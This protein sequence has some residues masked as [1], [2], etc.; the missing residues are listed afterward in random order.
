MIPLTLTLTNFL[1]WRE[2]A[3]LDFGSLHLAGITGSNGAGKSSL[4]EAITWSLFGRSRG[5]SDDDVVHR[6]AVQKGESA[7][8]IFIF[9][10]GESHYRV[11]RRKKAGGRMALEFQI[12][13]EEGGWT[14]L[15]ET[16]L[17][18]TQERIEQ[19]LGMNYDT[20]VNVSFFMQGQADAFT[21][22]TP[23]QRKEILAELLGVNRWDKLK[24][25]AVER[26]K[27]AETERDLIDARLRD[28]DEELA[29]SGDRE[30]E[31]AMARAG[32]EKAAALLAAQ[33]ALL[34]TLRRAAEAVSRQQEGLTRLRQQQERHTTRTA[35]LERLH[36]IRRRERESHQGWLDQRSAIEQESADHEAAWRDLE[37]WQAKAEQFN[38]V[39]H[40]RRPHELALAQQESTLRARQTALGA[41]Q[42]QVAQMRTERADL[43]AQIAATAQEQAA[44]GDRLERLAAE[45]VAWRE[46]R[47]LFQTMQGERRLR[48][49][50]AQALRKE[51]ATVAR[52]QQER[53]TL[54]ASAD[55][56]TRALADLADRLA[57]LE[58]DRER[59]ATAQGTL[60]ALEAQQGTLKAE[61]ARLK[62]RI[63]RLET[64]TGE[65]AGA[66][67]LCGQPLSAEHRARALADLTAEGKQRGDLFR[68]NQQ[69]AL[70]LKAETQRLTAALAQS[71]DLER[72]RQRQ[73]QA[74]AQAQARHD[75]IGRVVADWEAAQGADRLAQAEQFLADQAE[76]TAL[77]ERIAALETAL[78]PRADWQAALQTLGRQHARAEARL[79]EIDRTVARWDGEER[80]QLEEVTQALESADFGIAERQALAQ[81]EVQAVAIGYD[82][83]RHA[84]ARTR[85]DG[86]AEAPR[87]LQALREAEAAIKPLDDALADLAAQLADQAAHATELADQLALEEARLVT[88]RA[89]AGDLQ[90]AERSVAD[91]REQQIAANRR[92]GVAQQKVA[93][94]GDQRTRQATLTAEKGRVNRR[95]QQL[96]LL[97]K[98]CGRDGVQALLI[99]HALPQIED[100]ANRLLEQL[101]EGAMHLSFD[102][103]RQLRSRD[104]LRETL[105]I[106]ISDSNGERPYE[107][108]SGGEQFRIN[109]A[110]RL[111]LSRVLAQR[112]GARL[113]TL[114]IDEGF[115]SQDPGGRQ[116]LIEAINLIQDDFERI[117][118]ITHIDELRDAF[119]VRIEVS[120]SADGSRLR[121][122]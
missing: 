116:R 61:M 88:L 40:A 47:E 18:E 87:R 92:V 17:R 15:S 30:A 101:T 14:T 84:A 60:H 75:E 5:R 49:Q 10:L 21:T 25:R 66:C 1:S 97:E 8:V 111:A 26:R 96:Q 56:A 65:E 58:R 42:T 11:A 105:D 73:E 93:V 50:A 62:E 52:L 121:V 45:E 13:S 23:N 43:L 70:A 110:I 90:S 59:L 81:L 100:H 86:L 104:A 107:N 39:Q 22:R 35:D 106:T 118:V 53:V 55:T 41:Q 91:L 74:V 34:L 89:D 27:S 68:A 115:G 4:I 99:E 94:L 83:Q 64:E 32:F 54:S 77:Q 63:K 48:E 113:Q 38:A 44:L 109:F 29:L 7:A 76:M 102:T 98:A 3:T 19:T 95:I 12:G 82:A 79:A 2:S 9:A 24:E 6:V 57:S 16:K 46:A 69:E 71:A 72:S 36:A 122:L 120:K 114:V 112:S 103:Q 108:Y 51:A 80:A 117:L 119:P 20:F 28:I 67:P 85:R 31:L 33:E 78:K 37:A